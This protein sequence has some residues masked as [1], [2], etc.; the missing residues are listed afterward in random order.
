[1]VISIFFIN[2]TSCTRKSGFSG[3]LGGKTIPVFVS[4]GFI[5]FIDNYCFTCS[6]YN[7][8]HTNIIS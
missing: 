4:E 3:S 8:I 2:D 6:E 1:M 5:T 7:A